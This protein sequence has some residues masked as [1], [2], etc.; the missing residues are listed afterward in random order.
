MMPFNALSV[1]LEPGITLVE[2]SAGTGREGA[3]TSASTLIPKWWWSAAAARN[4]APRR[5]VFPGLRATQDRWS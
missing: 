2:A 5:A 3:P 4:A 1:P